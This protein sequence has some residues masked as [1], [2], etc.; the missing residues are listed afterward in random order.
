MPNCLTTLKSKKVQLFKKQKWN[1]WS[2]TMKL[3]Y[4]GLPKNAFRDFGKGFRIGFLQSCKKRNK[5]G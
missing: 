2:K 4:G 3:K 1:L 5:K